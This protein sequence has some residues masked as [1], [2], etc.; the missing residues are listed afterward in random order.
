MKDFSIVDN[1]VT[2]CYLLF[3][4]QRCHRSGALP[5][6]NPLFYPFF[7]TAQ[8]LS[9]IASSTSMAPNQLFQYSIVSALIDGVANKGLPLSDLIVNGNFGLGTFRHMVGEMIILD[10]LVYQMKS[11]G[12]VH[13]IQSTAYDQTIIPFAMI[14]D[15]QPTITA[16]VHIQS[17][18]ELASHLSQ[19]MADTRNHYLSFKIH[20]VFKAITVRTVGGQQTPHQGLAEIGKHQTS[21]SFNDIEGTLVGFRSPSF[22]QGISVAGDHLHFI[23]ADKKHGGHVLECEAIGEIDIAVAQLSDVHLRLPTMDEEYNQAQLKL[24]AQGISTVEG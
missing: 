23:S 17:K 18:Q 13:D 9:A 11:D 1:Y 3:F 22:M 10:G 5:H 4:K 16:S 12:S 21:H 24:D 14:T 19:I 20:G 6:T 15:F 2:D 8:F 7:D